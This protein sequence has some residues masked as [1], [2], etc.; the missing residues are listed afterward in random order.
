V[1]VGPKTKRRRRIHLIRLIFWACNIPVVL[2]LVLYQPK[3]S[4]PY[5]AVISVAANVEGAWS[6]FAADSPLDE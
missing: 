1:S 2:Y 3:L 4:I 6:S 5:I